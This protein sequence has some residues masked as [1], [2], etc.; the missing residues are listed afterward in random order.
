MDVLCCAQGKHGRG[1]QLSGVCGKAASFVI[2]PF[3][4]AHGGDIVTNGLAPNTLQNS[5]IRNGNAKQ[6][7]DP[8]IKNLN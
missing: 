1:Y 6:N 5:L 7:D 4:A 2:G 3:W 8:A